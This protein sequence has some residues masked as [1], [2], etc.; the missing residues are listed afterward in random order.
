MNIAEILILSFKNQSIF[1]KRVGEKYSRHLFTI[2]RILVALWVV[3]EDTI[4]LARQACN[5]QAMSR[6]MAPWVIHQLMVLIYI[7]TKILE[8]LASFNFRNWN[9][10]PQKLRTHY[11]RSVINSGCQFFSF[12]VTKA[13]NRENLTFVK[14]TDSPIEK[15]CTHVCSN[16][17]GVTY[18]TVQSAMKMSWCQTIVLKSWQSI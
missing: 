18:T 7:Y 6:L 14:D 11:S 1:F 12:I 5:M 13:K 9:A 17:D 15:C 8:K 16:V 2:W 4:H 10:I 3:M